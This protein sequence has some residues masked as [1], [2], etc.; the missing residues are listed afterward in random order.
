MEKLRAP[1]PRLST[2]IKRSED[3]DVTEYLLLAALIVLV[4]GVVIIHVMHRTV[5]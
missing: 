5:P 2:N 4:L 1:S 3:N